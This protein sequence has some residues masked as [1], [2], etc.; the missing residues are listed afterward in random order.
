MIRLTNLFLLVLTLIGCSG[1]QLK[2]GEFPLV[3]LNELDPSIEYDMRYVGKHNFVGRPIVGYYASKCYLSRDAAVALMRVQ[4]ELQAHRM[5][6]KIFDCY[7]PQKAVD[8]FKRWTLDLTDTKMKEEFYPNEDKKDFFA[9]GF[10]AA[11]SGHTRGS[12]V[13]LT[14]SGL[15]MGTDHDFFDIRSFSAYP[16]HSLVVRANRELLR[17]LMVKYGFAPLEE[18]W[19]HYRFINEPYPNKYFNRDVK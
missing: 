10:I 15:D 9:K 17:N 11:K 8:D 7:R 19:W 5:S 12:A 18:E 4:D 13:D 1:K 2:A 3:L 16:D 14:I 6:L